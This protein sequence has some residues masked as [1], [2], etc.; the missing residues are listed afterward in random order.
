MKAWVW[1]AT[2]SVVCACN[3]HQPAPP[4]PQPSESAQEKLL[5]EEWRTSSSSG[6]AVLIGRRDG[7]A[8]EV[9]CA[10]GDAG[11][12]RSECLARESDLRFVSDDCATFIKLVDTPKVEEPLARAVVGE[13]IS[14]NGP[15]TPLRLGK[16]AA[17]A[18]AR[19]SQSGKWFAWL[20]GCLEAAGEP[21]RSIDGGVAYESLDGVSHVITF[22]EA[23]AWVDAL[24][25][26]D[27][28]SAEGAKN[29][30]DDVALYQWED[31]SGAVMV[32]PLSQVPARY[33]EK[34]TRISSE[35]SVVGDQ[36]ASRDLSLSV[37]QRR[38]EDERQWAL[39]EQMRALNAKNSGARTTPIGGGSCGG[40]RATITSLENQ[41]SALGRS[42][43]KPCNATIRAA[44]NRD[45][46]DTLGN[47]QCRA[48]NEEA[49]KA[50]AAQSAALTSQLEN[51]RDGLRRAQVAGCN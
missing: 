19:V 45:I 49:A 24:P 23:S 41:L 39:D 47:Q 11:W 16:L 18:V 21:P 17:P 32:T 35:I 25:T 4:P 44:G 38:K 31:K 48:Q 37:A 36:K 1:T 51:A 8:C 5:P 33:R 43:D 10:S 46:Y 2:L 27:P 9:S 14:A 28:P 13:V 6:S 7:T 50:R 40:W 22:A 30:T 12:K 26:P 3:R 42:Q 20:R 34:A 15:P 29:G